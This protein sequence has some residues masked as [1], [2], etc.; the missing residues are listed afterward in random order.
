MKINRLIPIFLVI[1]LCLS[2]CGNPIPE[3]KAVQTESIST[4][5]L[6]TNEIKSTSGVQSNDSN[7]AGTIQLEETAETSDEKNVSTNRKLIKNVSV[8][9]ETT[10]LEKSKEQIE[11]AIKDANGYIENSN[12]ENN[13]DYSFAR[14][15]LKI[16]ID[17]NQL[18]TFSDSLNKIGTITFKNE[19]T[20]D[21]TLEYSDMESYKKTLQIE[22][23]RI[24]SLLE[25]SKDLEMIIQLEDK[26]SE[27]RYE[28]ERQESQLKL[29]DNLIEYSTIDLTLE[30]VE[31]ISGS[32]K[33]DSIFKR[34]GNGLKDTFYDLKVIFSNLFVFLIVNSPYIL[35][36]GGIITLIIIYRKKHPRKK[37]QNKTKNTEE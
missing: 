5:K 34:I 19:E 28:L 2:G 18:E 11:K 4:Q 16:R 6:E 36:I 24:L 21:V 20:K 15:H 35:I 7:F 13:K 23:E 37:K 22:Q 27:I 1:V 17:T 12:Y 14:Y 25:Q 33:N 10:E 8:K 30:E 29:Y 31:H 3:K 9:I 32:N 26:L